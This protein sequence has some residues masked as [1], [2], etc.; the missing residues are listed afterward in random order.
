MQEM[1]MH[2]DALLGK[3][4]QEN[5][6]RC[7]IPIYFEKRLKGVLGAAAKKMLIVKLPNTQIHFQ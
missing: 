4:L 3:I 6:G 1:G 2:H 7:D 5:L